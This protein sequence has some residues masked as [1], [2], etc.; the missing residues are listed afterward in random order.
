M[1]TTR[2]GGIDKLISQLSLSRQ[3]ETNNDDVKHDYTED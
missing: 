1:R 2:V 3:S